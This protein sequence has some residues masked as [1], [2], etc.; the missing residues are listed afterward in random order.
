[1]RPHQLVCYRVGDKTKGLYLYEWRERPA[2]ITYVIHQPPSFQEISVG[3]GD[4][5][6]YKKEG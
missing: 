5:N 4:W 1:M 6:E 2:V 3:G